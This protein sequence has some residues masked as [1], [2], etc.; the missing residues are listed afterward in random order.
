M[1]DIVYQDAIENNFSHEQMT[2]LNPIL[3]LTAML[4]QKIIG[5]FMERFGM[6][7]EENPESR[8]VEGISF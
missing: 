4:K 7:G 3:N 1:C 2:P 8:N 5:I 6:V